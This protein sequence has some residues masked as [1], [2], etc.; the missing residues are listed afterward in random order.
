ML[1]LLE[2]RAR[3]LWGS[4]RPTKFPFALPVRVP[5]PAVLGTAHGDEYI[6]KERQ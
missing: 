1:Q 4:R 3:K 2:E 6:G 5:V